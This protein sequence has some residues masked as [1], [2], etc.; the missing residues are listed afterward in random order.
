MQFKTSTKISLKFTFFTTIVLLIFSFLIFALFFRARYSKQEDRLLMNGEY[1]PPYLLEFV[2]TSPLGIVRE[3]MQIEKRNFPHQPQDVLLLEDITGPEKTRDSIFQ[4]IAVND[5]SF[6]KGYYT[7]QFLGYISKGHVSIFYKEG[8]YF[9]YRIERDKVKFLDIT[10]FVYAQMELVQ[11]LL[12]WDCLFIILVYLIS[13]YFVKSSLK[14]LKKLTHYAQHLDLDHLSVPLRIR[15][16]HHD[17]I[18]VISDAFNASLERIHT[19]IVALKDFI[20]NA[21]H[22]L[23]TPLMMISTEID[24]ALKKKDY[25]ERLVNIKEYVKRLSE[26]LDTLSLITRLESATTFAKEE[27]FVLTS[28]EEVVKQIEKKYPKKQVKVEV[29]KDL[30]VQAHSGLLEIVLKNLIENACKYTGNN[31][32]ISVV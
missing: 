24:I 10:E 32:E 6:D 12:F 17:E 22:E 16:H 29:K 25:E 5:F 8:E 11:L 19:Q 26:L 20:A 15:G 31:A 1:T 2:H 21:S 27:V 9:V 14:N 28:V 30:V 7:S 3:E 18:K 23:K 4:E 13:L